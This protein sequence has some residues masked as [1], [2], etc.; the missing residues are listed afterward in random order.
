MGYK[1]VEFR[2]TPNPDALKCMIEPQVRPLVDEAG[3]PDGAKR[4]RAYRSGEEAQGD[5]LAMVLFAVEGV[6]SVLIHEQWI[7][8]NKDK[9]VPWASLKPL[10]E[11]A[12]REAP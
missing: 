11:K 4:P 8:V 7:S 10:I 9:A 1:V 5:P 3:G 12:L 6:S 2:Q